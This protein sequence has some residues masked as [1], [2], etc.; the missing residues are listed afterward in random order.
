MSAG[1]LPPSAGPS[2]RLSAS[3]QWSLLSSAAGADPR[4]H[5]AASSSA[6][7]A[8]SCRVLSAPPNLAPS[9][10]QEP[11]FESAHAAPNL[12]GCSGR[13]R[14]DEGGAGRARATWAGLGSWK[15][16]LEL[17]GVGEGA[18]S[19]GVGPQGG[20][21][22]IALTGPG[23]R[24][25]PHRAGP[26]GKASSG[27]RLEVGPEAAARVQTSRGSRTR[28]LGVGRLRRGAS[29]QPPFSYRSSTLNSSCVSR[30]TS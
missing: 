2:R 30:L 17:A 25:A 26:A 18:R 19:Q 24:R 22:G 11:P 21:A 3:T 29:P 12:I 7:L 16:G 14:G 13:T 8:A 28:S 4:P 10:P 6:G 27:G 15:S 20:L 23:A 1:A 9:L 5:P